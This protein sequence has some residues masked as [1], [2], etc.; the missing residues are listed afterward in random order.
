MPR[1]KKNQ[2]PDKRFRTRLDLGKDEAGN[3]VRKTFY[4]T[5]L[6]EAESKK[7]EYIRLHPAAGTIADHSITFGAWA[8]RWLATYN[9]GIEH[10]TYENRKYSL[11]ALK[12]IEVGGMP[13]A[14]H[15]LVE[16]R[17]ADVQ[18]VAVSLNGKSI[19]TI[20]MAR[21]LLQNVFD[22]AVDN[23]I[24]TESPY[25]RIKMPK[26]TYTGNRALEGWEK[27]VIDDT[28]MLHRAGLWAMIALYAG[29][30]RGELAHLRWDHIDM[31]RRTI[32]IDGAVSFRANR[33]TDKATK[34]EAGARTVPILDPL[35][36]AMESVE[37][38]DGFVCKSARGERLT[39]S[40]FDR[41]W[42]G[43]QL[44][45]ERAANGIEPYARTIGW[46]VDLARQ[47]E[48]HKIFD[49]GAHDLRYTYATMLYDADVDLKT[50]QYLLGHDDVM[51]TMKIYTKLS[52]EKKA[53]S[54]TKLIE[55]FRVGGA[56]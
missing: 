37:C 28:W 14:D 31:D 42:E 19:G 1:K 17:P 34:T 55:H 54:V 48:G 32:V 4:G 7:R 36:A 21:W 26:G 2:M 29:L 33:P 51:T 41:G 20:S 18:A 30:R 13:L 46:R 27:A 12:R 39:E 25:K 45:C 24:L 38:R 44:V 43:W 53:S 11:N 23:R 10:Y 35:Y 50:A 6:E 9:T 3:R 49:V 5:T 8:D 52:K 40:A 16:L 56:Q 22:T 15:V 47:K